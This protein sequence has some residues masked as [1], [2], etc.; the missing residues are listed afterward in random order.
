MTDP[1]GTR[2]RFPPDDSRVYPD[3]GLHG[4]V[5]KLIG[6][7]IVAGHVPPSTALPPQAELMD[8][9][10]VSRTAVREAMKVLAAKGLVAS[11]PKTG[12]LVRPRTEWN[13]L[14][15]DV[16]SWHAVHNMDEAMIADLTALRDLIEPAVVRMAA[17]RATPETLAPIADA[18]AAMEANMNNKEDY[19]HADL[20]F[21][22][23]LFAACGN[24]FFE[25]LGSVVRAL[26]SASFR[27]QRQSVIRPSE[28]YALHLTVLEAIQARDADAA[29]AAMRAIVHR[30]RDELSAILTQ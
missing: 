14:D 25:C 29:E 24:P 13:L 18:L 9:L 17:E 28:G 30:A 15:P 23:A 11:M 3:R 16:L 21:H 6:E 22:E 19:Y 8:E 2:T 26:L 20:A 12:T 10:G 5:V 1:D 4:R 7:R 27:I